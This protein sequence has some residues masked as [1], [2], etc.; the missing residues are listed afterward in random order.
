MINFKTHY[1]Q[2]E[3]VA[4]LLIDR[5]VRG[6]SPNRF[7]LSFDKLTDQRASVYKLVSQELKRVYA[8]LLAN[9]SAVDRMSICRC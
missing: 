9:L 8:I 5:L 6:W 7:V 4:P 2:H 3:A 1:I